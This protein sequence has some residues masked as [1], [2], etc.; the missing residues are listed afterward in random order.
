MNIADPGF[1]RALDACAAEPIHLIGGIQPPGVLLVFHLRTRRL[2]AASANA[3]PLFEADGVEALLGTAIEELLDGPTLQAVAAVADPAEPAASRFAG[4]TN[5][6]PMGALHEVSAHAVDELVHVELEPAQAP[7]MDSGDG[8]AA[9]AR[10]DAAAAEGGLLDAIAR[11]VQ[12]VS[13]HSRVMVYRF[14][15]D[16]TGEV[17]AEALD[18]PLPSYL[19]LRYPASDIP[20]QAR[21]LYVHNRVRVIADVAHAPVPVHRDPALDAPL[22]MR[23]DVLRAV[24]PV[25]LE[26]LR[27]MG[28][29][30][31]MSVSLVVDGRL[32]GMVACHHH[33]PRPVSARARRALDMLG[34]H[35]SMILDARELRARVRREDELRGHRDELERLLHE[36]ADPRAALAAH[37][38]VVLATVPADG[39]VLCTGGER[40]ASGS[41]PPADGVHAALK[42]ARDRGRAGIAATHVA[43][44]WSTAPGPEAA[45]LLA[46]PLGAGHDDWLLLF[47]RE[48]RRTVRWAGRPDRPFQ[49]DADGGRIGPRTSFAAWE[50]QVRDTSAPWIARDLELAQR[51]RLVVERY[52]PAP[53]AAPVRG[54]DAEDRLMDVEARE[55]AERLR[56]LADLLAS[57]R[58][59]RERLRRLRPML[60]QLEDALGALAG[61][62]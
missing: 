17:E 19:G 8:H 62:D 45:G 60:S 25:H 1:Q 44:D 23:F 37:L 28:V 52:L 40:H 43:S 29:A 46:V 55:Q 49:I 41:L 53:P 34:R 38:D 36:A 12:A 57:A 50:E 15:P 11:Q 3:A 39:A 6:G 42:W 27:N 58:P 13:G 26:Y 22:D 30:A 54:A 61:A 35:V 21:A 33:E 20:P 24:S 18:G 4:V 14:L 32:W 48:Q 31:S 5:A 7:R 16:G 9:I 2:V 51:L 59:G 47:R 10:L 56:R